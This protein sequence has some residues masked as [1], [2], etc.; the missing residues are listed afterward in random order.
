MP[1]QCTHTD[2]SNVQWIDMFDQNPYKIN[3]FQREKKVHTAK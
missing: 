1:V 3:T 2:K